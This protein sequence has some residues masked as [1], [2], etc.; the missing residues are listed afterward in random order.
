MPH[1]TAVRDA[2]EEQD[3]LLIQRALDPENPI[4]LSRELDP[5]EKADDA[6]N[7]S[8][9]DDDDLAE[10]EDDKEEQQL[11]VVAH[12]PEVDDLLADSGHSLKGKYPQD[13]VHGDDF[14]GDVLD[15]LFGE[16]SS[17]PA[18]NETAADDVGHHRRSAVTVKPFDTSAPSGYD[19]DRRSPAFASLPH[20]HTGGG[21]VYKPPSSTRAGQDVGGH[22]KEQQLQQELFAMSGTAVGKLD[23]VP[24]IE[25]QEDLLAALWPRFELDTVP[26]FMDLLPT[27]TARYIGKTPL[28]RPK[29]VQPTRLN[30][31]I[32]VDQ[33]KSFRL[34]SGPNRRVQEETGRLGLITIEK[35][36]SEGECDD[37]QEDLESD[38]ECDPVGGV[39]WQD[40]QILCED[41]DTHTSTEASSQGTPELVPKQQDDTLGD[42]IDNFDS[43]LE[44]PPAKVCSPEFLGF[45]C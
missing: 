43:Q 37:D 16:R 11:P 9:L 39:S 26:K 5:G 28:R 33:E 45:R 8:D 41:W 21:D 18:D 10:D 14:H 32:A 27:K 4:D 25:T 23:D 36:P 24:V 42:F 44:L 31:E 12:S 7:F 1:A 22:S 19:S 17:S 2:Q 3:D 38:F 13:H 40:L 6:V 15:D 34:A 30:L 29:P 20:I 35:E